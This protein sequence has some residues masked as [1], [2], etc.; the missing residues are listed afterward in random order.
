MGALLG[1]VL[2]LSALL[3]VGVKSLAPVTVGDAS[4]RPSQP[5]LSNQAKTIVEAAA[6]FEIDVPYMGSIETPL[7]AGSIWD[8]EAPAY[9]LRPSD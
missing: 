1:A 3:M 6:P 9:D 4:M 2:L 7:D 5:N 8:E